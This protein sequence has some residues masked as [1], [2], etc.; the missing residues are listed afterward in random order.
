MQARRCGSR[1]FLFF[2][3]QQES[4]SHARSL[5]SSGS[6]SGTVC[7][8]LCLWVRPDVDG[9]RKQEFSDPPR[10]PRYACVIVQRELYPLPPLS[11][12]RQRVMYCTHLSTALVI[13]HYLTMSLYYCSI[14]VPNH[15]VTLPVQTYGYSKHLVLLRYRTNKNILY[16]DNLN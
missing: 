2:L 15:S 12:Y 3:S 13:W 7:T 8:S 11:R 9:E 6:N 1:F 16:T 5:P 4:W 10:R 14:M